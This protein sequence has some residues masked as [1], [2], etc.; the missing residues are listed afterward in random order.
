MYKTDDKC[1]IL[2]LENFKLGVIM[3]MLYCVVLKNQSI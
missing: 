2:P 1:K 3:G